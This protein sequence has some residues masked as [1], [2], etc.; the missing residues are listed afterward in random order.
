MSKLNEV[1]ARL[2]AVNAW[3]LALLAFCL[4]LSAALGSV[5]SLLFMALWLLEGDYRRK[6]KEM[7]DNPMTWAVLLYLAVLALGILWNAHLDESLREIRRQWKVLLIPIFLTGLRPGEQRRVIGAFIAGAG[8]MALSTVLVWLDW[9]RYP[10]VSAKHM[11]LVRSGVTYNPMLAFALYLVLHQLIWGQALRF[12]MRLFLAPLLALMVVSMFMTGGRAGQVGFLV[13]LAL[14]C[15]QCLR[16]S[17]WRAALAMILAPVLVFVAAYNQSPVF[18]KRVEQAKSDLLV[19]KKNPRSSVGLRL[20]WSRE[21]LDMMREAPF[22]VQLVGV[23]TGGFKSAYAT[24][25]AEHSPKMPAAP[26][27]PH[28]QY[29]LTLVQNGLVGVAALLW[30]FITQIRLAWRRGRRGREESAGDWSRARLALPLFFLVIM[31]G[32]SYLLIHETGLLFAL[33]SAVLYKGCGVRPELEYRIREKV[34]VLPRRPIFVGIRELS[35]TFRRR[36]FWKI[37]QREARLR[38]GSGRSARP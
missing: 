29:V 23:G 36:M 25:H 12:R 27:N 1:R 22:A 15:V 20:F 6:F 38:R 14:W 3:V 5:L 34:A 9:L 16:D 17:R 11:I 2:G 21:S 19:F 8:L 28:N 24:Y 37:R 10:R 4:P 30:L 7:R 13:L 31:L 18:H 32:E 35:P 26:G 33:M